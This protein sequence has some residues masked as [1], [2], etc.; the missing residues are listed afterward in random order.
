MIIVI[1]IFGK[2]NFYKMINGEP[3]ILSTSKGK[4]YWCPTII[5]PER[6][7]TARILS[8]FELFKRLK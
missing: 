3:H 8:D 1:K 7:K 4:E 2:D 6:M 5:D